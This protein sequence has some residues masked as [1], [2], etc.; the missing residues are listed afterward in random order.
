MLPPSAQN[1]PN[2]DMSF[3]RQLRAILL[4]IV[5]PPSSWDGKGTSPLWK[6]K[7]VGIL[8]LHS[9]FLVL[10]TVLS[11]LVARLDG[12]IV[13]DLVKGDG[14]GFLKGLGLWFVLAIPSTYTNSMVSST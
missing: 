9:A 5:L 11:I 4:R 10:R 14:K 1:K 2:I 13:R 7:E 8:T 3:L 6:S 12:R